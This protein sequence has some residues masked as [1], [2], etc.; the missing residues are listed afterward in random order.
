MTDLS[1]EILES[2]QARHT[3]K[4]KA[5]FITF[6]KGR[7]S[8]LS[9]EKGGLFGGKN[10]VLGDVS[11]AKVVFGAHYDT[12]AVLPFPNL[13]FPGNILLSILYGFVPAVPLFLLTGA[14]T[15]LTG[16]FTDNFWLVE[17]A[18]FLPL[19]LFMWMLYFGVPNRH[20][21]NDNTSGVVAALELYASLSH[22]EREK[23]AFV[24]FDN[25][26]LGLLG[27]AAFYRRHKKAMKEKLLI[28]ADCVSD[29]DE[30]WLL[31][32]KK[33]AKE[34]EKALREVFLGVS[35]KTVTVRSRKGTIYP[36]D[37][38]SFP[39]SVGVA[40]FKKGF[41]GFYLDR[42]H[43][44]RDTVFD[45]ENIRVFVSGFEKFVRAL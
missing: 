34:D 32:G 1:R 33:V 28:N 37:Q 13:I 40:A 5:A 22:E 38:A 25:E 23:V 19:L 15:Y 45:E 21:A 12:C 2:W 9:V 7:L 26:E 42:I 35:G 18:I 17:A 14:L 29:G 11:Q 3:K 39:V 36:S 30:L 8:A 31:L 16:R 27:S 10:L 20:T 43:T 4:Q 44:S 24:L 6:L 41:L